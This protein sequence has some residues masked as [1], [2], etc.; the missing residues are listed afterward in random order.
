MAGC[1]DGRVCRCKGDVREEWTRMGLA[2]TSL[3]LRMFELI[4]TRR[5][6]RTDAHRRTRTCTR[7]RTRGRGRTTRDRR[8][9]TRIHDRT[10]RSWK[11]VLVGVAALQHQPLPEHPTT[12]QQQQLVLKVV[13]QLCVRERVR[14]THERAATMH[15]YPPPHTHTYT[16]TYAQAHT[17]AITHRR[18]RTDAH[19]QT[20]T[21]RRTRTDAHAKT[22]RRT[23]AH[24][25]THTHTHTLTHTRT[26][27]RTRTR[28][29]AKTHTHTR[30]RAHAY[31]HNTHT[32]AHTHTRSGGGSTSWWGWRHCNTSHCRRTQRPGS[33]SRQLV[34]KVVGQLCV[35]V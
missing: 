24:A 1:A 12:W 22:H 35:C 3:R 9:R 16:Y 25:K 20:H 29:H 10:Q 8:V 30:I 2:L 18:T 19:A 6:T 26:D 17:H 28:T 11:H 32:H 14:F 34:L 13:G 33:S 5:C 15:G 7:G 31:T 21:H 4:R 23:D 27:T